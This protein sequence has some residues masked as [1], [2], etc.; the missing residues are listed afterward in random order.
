[1]TARPPRTEERSMIRRDRPDWYRPARPDPP[2][3]PDRWPFNLPMGL[4]RLDPSSFFGYPWNQP[5]A[6]AKSLSTQM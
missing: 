4:S 2:A 6:N 5:R 3:N 1:M